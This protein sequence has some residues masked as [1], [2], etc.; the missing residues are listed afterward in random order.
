MLDEIKNLGLDREKWKA[1][2]YD[3]LRPIIDECSVTILVPN[4][5]KRTLNIRVNDSWGEMVVKFSLSFM[6][7]CKGILI[8]HR[9][10]VAEKWRNNGISKALWPIKRM[11]AYD[12]R[13]GMLTC[14]VTSDNKIQ[15]KILID[16]NWHY[17]GSFRNSRTG[18]KIY[19]YSYRML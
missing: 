8:L 18:N 4:A 14:T 12:L 6:P 3:V 1:D 9:M 13:V 2:I 17:T 11:I 7:G 15:Q 19:M 10:E 5:H 16:A